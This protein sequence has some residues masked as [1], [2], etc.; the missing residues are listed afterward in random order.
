MLGASNCLARSD[1]TIIVATIGFLAMVMRSRDMMRLFYWLHCFCF[2]L[3]VVWVGVHGDYLH[4]FGRVPSE[5]HRAMA[6][7]IR[8]HK[9]SLGVSIVLILDKLFSFYHLYQFYATLPRD[10]VGFRDVQKMVKKLGSRPA[11]V[12]A[13]SRGG[14]AAGDDDEGTAL[15]GHAD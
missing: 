14:A 12:P 11:D 13:P 15:N 2:L 5:A 8:L 1:P 3:D 4:S 9:W 10:G 7:L 6:N